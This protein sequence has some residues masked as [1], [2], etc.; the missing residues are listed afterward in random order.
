MPVPAPSPKPNARVQGQ[1]LARRSVLCALWPLFLFCLVGLSLL[2]LSG[3]A[4]AEGQEGAPSAAAGGGEADVP[5]VPGGFAVRAIAQGA[6]ELLEGLVGFPRPGDAGPPNPLTLPPEGPLEIILR[7]SIPRAL[8]GKACSA[9]IMAVGD[10]LI[11]NTMRQYAANGDGG[12]DFKPNFQYVRPILAQGDLVIGNLENPLAG[13]DRGLS[14]YPNFNAPQELAGD[15][16]ANGFTT[17]LLS[18]NHS[19][20]RGWNG[21]ETTIRTVDGAGLDY[22][23]AY[24][25]GKDKERRLISV[26]NGLRIAIL[27]YTYGLNGYPGPKAGEEWRLGVIDRELIFSDLRLAWDQGADF[28]IVSLHFGNEYQRSPDKLQIRLVQELLAGDP[29]QGLKGPD[30][31]LGSHPHVVQPFVQ[32]ETGPDGASQAVM[33]SLGNF[34]TSQPYAYTYLGLIL[35]GHL[36]LEADGRKTIGPFTLIPTYCRKGVEDGRKFYRVIPMAQAAGRPADFGLSEDEAMQMAKDLEEIN[37]HLVSLE[38]EPGRWPN[39]K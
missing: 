18:N 12:F 6:R 37:R 33:Y 10:I 14:G 7:H 9:R 20:D 15:L 30:L 29:P 2:A 8:A 13:A 21:L 4:V 27:A 25:D 32:T 5:P 19:L 34:M 24:L 28:V 23:G 17:V 39:L 11:H 22:A 36:T 35:D 31:I 16:K 3:P 1:F 38:P 26:F